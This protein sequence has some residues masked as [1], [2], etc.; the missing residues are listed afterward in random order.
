MVVFET[1]A[2][3]FMFVLL[4][5]ISSVV[6]YI[7]SNKYFNNKISKNKAPEVIRKLL[8]T[9]IAA[10]FVYF[11]FNL[12]ILVNNQFPDILL[13]F[14]SQ[15]LLLLSVP[16]VLISPNTKDK[17]KIK[18]EYPNF[19]QSRKGKIKIGKLLYNNKTKGWYRL[20][21]E[22]LKRHMFICGL[23]GS[24]KSNFLQFFLKNFYKKYDVPFLLSEFKG[25]YIHLQET[26][27]DLIILR[28]GENYSIN[29]FDPELSEPE[30]HAERILS[31]LTSGG[32]F[33][34]ANIEYTPQM[35][36]VLYDILL[37]ICSNKETRNWE[38]FEK[39]ST[40][41]Q[42]ANK[43]EI[44]YLDQSVSAI[45]N[46]LRRYN[47]GAL[48]TIFTTKS[49]LNIKDLFN[50]RVLLDLSSI[51]RLGGRKEDALFFL[52]MILKYIWDQNI[53]RGSKNY[54]DIKHITIVED[55]QYFAPQSIT[56]HT[57]LTSFI[58]DIALLLRGT[59]ECL[60]SL[61]TRP[62]ISKDVLANS[63]VFVCFKTHMEKDFICNLLNL[64]NAHEPFLSM[65]NTGECFIRV[66]S[67]KKPFTLQIPIVKRKWLTESAIMTRNQEILKKKAGQLSYENSQDQN[68]CSFCATELE[69]GE[70]V[71][72]YCQTTLKNSGWNSKAIEKLVKSSRI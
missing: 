2:S 61:A 3:Y 34:E 31:I 62:A 9:L 16:I 65:L 38:S 48:K 23:T 69:K 30:I 52:N 4:I 5:F 54:K 66:N 10:F 42:K 6:F 43:N 56:E 46:R 1:L 17:Y 8:L 45:K 33:E 68:K 12:E 50:L 18:L 28:P 41:Y 36:R 55:M 35:E 14:G 60:I 71:C 49:K 63:G 58:E 15:V 39:I 27:P 57:K 59:G 29:I 32:L 67:I 22:D 26:I 64:D 24:G 25:E 11:I 47:I 44:K 37:K 51:I 7:V 19:A 70:I 53:E 72:P 13:T 40:D 20:N 21:I